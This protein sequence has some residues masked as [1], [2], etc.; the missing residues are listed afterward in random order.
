VHIGIE[1]LHP[2]LAGRLGCGHGDVGVAQQLIRPPPAV[3]HGDADRG[4]NLQLLPVDDDRSTDGG[5]QRLGH[6]LRDLRVRA[7]EQD[8]ELVAAEA[9][10]RVLRAD[11][12]LDP[13]GQGD[14]QLIA[15]RVAETVV[16]PLEV[17]DADE[18]HRHA[19]SV[20]A[21]ELEGHLDP[22][23]ELAAVGQR[24]E[25]V[26][27]RLVTQLGLEVAQLLERLLETSAL[28]HDAEVAGQRLEQFEVGLIE[29]INLADAVADE[30]RAHDPLVPPDHE[31]HG[32]ADPTLAQ[33]PHQALAVGRVEHAVAVRH[34]LGPGPLFRIEGDRHHGLDQRA[35]S[36]VGP[37]RLFA[38]DARIERDLRPLR[39]EHAACLGQQPDDRRVDLGGPVQHAGGLVGDVEVVAATVS[40]EVAAVGQE[41]HAGGHPD[42]DAPAHVSP[43]QVD[44]DEGDHRRGDRTGQ[45]EG[46]HL[47]KA[48]DLGLAAGQKGGQG[49][50]HVAHQ[51]DEDGG[52]QRARPS[53]RTEGLAPHDLAE[54]DGGQNPGQ[55]EVAGVE[56]E[57]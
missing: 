10:R 17:V 29:V 16:D 36:E 45:S 19:R 18:E 33:G 27:V 49:D 48:V 52:Q 22:F 6:R 12:L 3:A 5:E 50:G 9:R 21:R 13:P 28:E 24:R 37:H 47:A 57:L 39:S 14:Q 30:D 46:E 55:E 35:R 8:A 31:H 7:V 53:D 1:E 2:V 41:A 20:T 34:A 11:H 44:G 23:D 54:D 51:G 15:D 4:P 38:V 56:S 42:E 32:F 26:V 40:L 43:Q 25:G